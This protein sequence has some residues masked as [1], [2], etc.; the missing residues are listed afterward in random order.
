MMIFF[1]FNVNEQKIQIM[2]APLVFDGH[3]TI[4]YTALAVW[5]CPRVLTMGGQQCHGAGICQDT[6]D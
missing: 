1:I 4:V 3:S 6:A 5:L 2:Q